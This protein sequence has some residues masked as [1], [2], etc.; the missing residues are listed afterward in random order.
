[1]ASGLAPAFEAGAVF[2]LSDKFKFCVLF[3]QSSCK[4]RYTRIYQRLTII[5]QYEKK[6]RLNILKRLKKLS[7]FSPEIL[8]HVEKYKLNFWSKEIAKIIFGHKFKSWKGNNG[9]DR[10]KYYLIFFSANFA[11]PPSRIYL[12]NHNS[13]HFGWVNTF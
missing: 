6:K 12:Y 13:K 8:S 3:K 5:F 10:K 11:H 7:S 4:C 1:L 2:P 9:D